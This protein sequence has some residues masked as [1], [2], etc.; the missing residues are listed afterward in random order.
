MIWYSNVKEI[1]VD[2]LLV[3]EEEMPEIKLTKTHI[4]LAIVTW[5]KDYPKW[6]L[7]LGNMS[8]KK[9]LAVKTQNF[10][11]LKRF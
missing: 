11:V 3:Q 6:L 5:L 1:T 7:I 9:N 2:T 4:T 8:T 10:V